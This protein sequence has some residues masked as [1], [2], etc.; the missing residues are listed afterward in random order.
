MCSSEPTLSLRTSPIPQGR[1]LRTNASQGPACP[2]SHCVALR[3]RQVE[4]DLLKPVVHFYLLREDARKF[5]LSQNESGPE[6]P[7][8]IP[9]IRPSSTRL[10]PWPF[11][12]KSCQ[13]S[14]R[15]FGRTT[16]RPYGSGDCFLCISDCHVQHIGGG[17]TLPTMQLKSL[18]NVR[19]G[20]SSVSCCPQSCM[21]LHESATP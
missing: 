2:T 15:N 16:R 8:L 5:L 1:A 19:S 4:G 18:A 21:T 13:P 3:H 10:I 11:L 17:K 14:Q 12:P 6:H 7:N 9:V 20:T